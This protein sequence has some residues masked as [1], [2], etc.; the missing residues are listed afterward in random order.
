M[1]SYFLLYC[2]EG[3]STACESLAAGKAIVVER[4]DDGDDDDNSVVCGSVCIKHCNIPLL[5]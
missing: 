1:S 4:K 5:P 2:K 3:F